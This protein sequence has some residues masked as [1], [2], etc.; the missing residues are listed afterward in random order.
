MPVNS[1]RFDERWTIPGFSP[2]EVYDVLADAKLLPDWWAGVYIQAT[3]E[4]AEASPHVGA[5]ARVR[6]RGFLP[7]CILM[8]L[9]STVLEP[10]KIVEVRTSGDLEGTWRATLSADGV[11]GTYVDIMQ[12]VVAQ[13]PLIRL[14]SPLL[15]PLFAWNHYWTSPR[16]QAGLRAYLA[17]RR[18][19]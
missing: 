17:R 14:L 11:G 1:Y 2:R 15:K 12:E 6:A 3:P 13:K 16:G 5:R 18:G 19:D 8:T 4:D 10:G 7:Y 9:E